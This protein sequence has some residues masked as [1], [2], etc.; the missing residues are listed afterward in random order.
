MKKFLVVAA[1]LVLLCGASTS[2]AV[3]DEEVFR[4][5]SLNLSTPGARAVAMGGAFIGLADD[6]TAA[7]TNPAGLSILAK[8]EVSIQYRYANGRSLNN[9]II[10]IPITNMDLTPSPVVPGEDTNTF[11]EFHSNDRQEAVNELG[12]VSFVYPMDKFTFAVSRH[13]LIN[14]DAKL[15]GSLSASPF[16]FVEPNSFQGASTISDTNYNFSLAGKLNDKFSIGGSVKISD[17]SFKSKIGAREKSEQVYGEHFA[18]SIDNSGTKVGFN[19]GVL[20]HPTSRISMGGVYKYEPKFTLD[21]NVLNTDFHPNPLVVEK[22]GTSQVDFDV[23]DTL[24]FGISVVPVKG[25][26]LNLD[27]V[28]V[29]YSQL[30]P[31]DTGYSLFTHLLPTIDPG[32]PGAPAPNLIHFAIDDSTDIHLGGEYLVTSGKTTFGFRA[33]YAREGRNRFYLASADNRYVQAFLEPIFGLNPGND[34]THWTT[35]LGVTQ[36]PI[37]L[38]MAVDMTMQDAIDVNLNNILNKQVIAD[39]GVDIIFSA[40]YRF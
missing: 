30:E 2:F 37:Q 16:H 34:V 23:P 12:F 9:N 38:D 24:G 4:A 26:H 5:F 36:G 27:I 19:V 28:R 7:E 25:V 32:H 14:S 21:A 13:E 15:F 22:S 3:T 29:F 8:P 40:V 18:T 10:G 17:F 1:A 35:G 39:A 20:V 33:G 11:A 31:V 6:A